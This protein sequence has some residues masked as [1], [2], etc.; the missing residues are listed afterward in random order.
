M[1]DYRKVGFPL[2]CP[3]GVPTLVARANQLIE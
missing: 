2:S 1:L 3:T